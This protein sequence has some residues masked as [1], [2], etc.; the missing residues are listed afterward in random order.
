MFAAQAYLRSKLQLFEGMDKADAQRVVVNIGEGKKALGCVCVCVC[1][2]G[3]L[4]RAQLRGRRQQKRPRARTCACHPQWAHTHTHTHTQRADDPASKRV[5]E[6][7]SVP[8]VTYS[9]SGDKRA[10]VWAEKVALTAWETEVRGRAGGGGGVERK[11]GAA[12]AVWA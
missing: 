2:S 9:A 6:A 1:V 12:V 4:L 10:D 11:G 8:V 3:R 7:C 5:L